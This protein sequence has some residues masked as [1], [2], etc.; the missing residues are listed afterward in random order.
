MRA[1]AHALSLLAV[2]LNAEILIALADGSRPL[3]EVRREAGSPP[4]TTLRGHLRRLSELGIVERRREHGFPGSVDYELGAAGRDLLEVSRVLE[5][6]LAEAPEG[7]LELG[8]TAA[9]SAIKA[10]VDGW[11]TSIVRALAA[12]PLSLTE[13]NRLISGLNY[14]S[15]E[16]RLGAMRLAGQ[17]EARPGQ[18]RGTP[19]AVTGWLRRAVGPLIAA[20][21]WER[22]YKPPGAAPL[23]RIDIEATFLLS[24]PLLQLPVDRSGSCSLGVELSSSGDNSGLVGVGVQVRDG[25][26]VSCVSQLRG[27]A[28]AWV[29]GSVSTWLHGVLEEDTERFE[30]GGDYQLATAILDGL[31]SVLAPM[32]R[33]A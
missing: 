27:E 6:W 7:P 18:S 21:R 33:R 11:S 20:A 25:R 16:R 2:P 24:M 12:R 30:I 8:T 26:I 1:G 29:S 4:Q 5:G 19:Y 17:I 23:G 13:L 31:A 9:K 14:P 15:L 28:Q 10:L 22:R 32:K 3:I